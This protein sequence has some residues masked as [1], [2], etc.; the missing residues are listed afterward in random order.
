MHVQ[1][2]VQLCG[3]SPHPAFGFQESSSA[4]RTLTK[5]SHKYYKVNKPGMLMVMLMR[6]SRK[7]RYVSGSRNQ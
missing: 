4:C 1:V 6:S 7:D 5:P 3:V 2:R